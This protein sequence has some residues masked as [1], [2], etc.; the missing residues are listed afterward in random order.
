MRWLAYSMILQAAA[1]DRTENVQGIF[2][3][4][5]QSCH[6]CPSLTSSITD[7]FI[8]FALSIF[9]WFFFFTE[10]L[11]LLPPDSLRNYF[12]L[13]FF[14]CTLYLQGFWGVFVNSIK[15]DLREHKK[16]VVHRKSH[17]PHCLPLNLKNKH[18]NKC[19]L[20]AANYQMIIFRQV[21]VKLRNLYS[22]YKSQQISKTLCDKPC[23]W[24]LLFYPKS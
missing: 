14:V 4:P 22:T 1:W 19:S 12:F 11:S 9:L 5:Q 24:I 7:C 13:V 21:D 23:Y 15:G 16:K 8:V 6:Y 2:F 18:A 10:F 3:F 17:Y 20:S